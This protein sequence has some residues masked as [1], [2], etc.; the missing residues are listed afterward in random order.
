MCLFRHHKLRVLVGGWWRKSN[1]PAPQDLFLDYDKIP[2][3][4]R[5]F[6]ERYV[7]IETPLLTCYAPSDLDRYTVIFG[8]Q[9]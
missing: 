9:N 6:L 4:P 2:K 7:L 1:R 5:M 8:G 3:E